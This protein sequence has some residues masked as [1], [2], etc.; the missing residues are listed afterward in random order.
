MTDRLTITTSIIIAYIRFN[1]LYSLSQQTCM[2]S[3]R[4][5]YY[6]IQNF[7]LFYPLNIFLFFPSAGFTKLS[8][9]LPF[10]ATFAP[11]AALY[12]HRW[13]LLRI[14]RFF[15]VFKAAGLAAQTLHVCEIFCKIKLKH[16]CN[17]N[18][19]YL[20]EKSND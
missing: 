2:L 20:Y 18:C 1:F 4:I 3:F 19:L 14:F 8:M 6:T 9:L 10:S 17:K 7:L 15:I 13:P 11:L 16:F 12:R 5:F